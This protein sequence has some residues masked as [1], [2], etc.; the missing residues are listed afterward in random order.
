[1]KEK[2]EQLLQTF[3]NDNKG[4]KVTN[5]N[6]QMLQLTIMNVVN[7][8]IQLTQNEINGYKEKIKQLEG[9]KRD[10]GCDKETIEGCD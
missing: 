7:E 2:I 4:E 3:F 5:W 10:C 1:M 9:S 8:Q 6:F